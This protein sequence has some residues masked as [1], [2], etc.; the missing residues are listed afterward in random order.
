ML[1][2]ICLFSFWC[3]TIVRSLCSNLDVIV[4][5]FEVFIFSNPFPEK[6]NV[7]HRVW[8]NISSTQSKSYQSK[9]LVHH[10]QIIYIMWNIFM[11][12]NTSYVQTNQWI[13][14]DSHETSTITW[15]LLLLFTIETPELTRYPNLHIFVSQACESPFGFIASTKDNHMALSCAKQIIQ[16]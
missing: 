7:C 15:V 14:H 5:Q 12:H 2:V 8:N 4:Q 9:V 6:V 16:E 3:A 13:H 1:C 10:L 11:P